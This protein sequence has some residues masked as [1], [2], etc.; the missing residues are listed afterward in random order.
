MGERHT[1]HVMG[2][3]LTVEIR[4]RVVPRR[5]LERAFGWLRWVDRTFSTYD[6]GS[7]IS[8][9]NAGDLGLSEAH[10]L[11]RRVLAR[12]ETLRAGT[13]GYFDANAPL[14]GGVDPS[15]LVKGWAVD[16]A[17]AGL[18]RA[19]AR[20]LCIEAG[21][22]LRVAG[23]P[24]RIGIRNPRRRDQLAAVVVLRNGAVATSGAYERGP[25]VVDPHTGRPPAGTLSVTMIDH[26]LA[27]ADAHATA[28]F[29][30][31]PRGPVWSARLTAMTILADDQVLLTPTFLRYRA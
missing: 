14:R 9:L 5:A 13:D 27:Q 6:A 24:W 25:H 4:D 21:G 12:C 29:A 7:E 16:V 31:G 3:A 23:G 19:G 10:P 11:V 15:G 20:Q 1:Q 2:T 26:T 17:F 22:D 18:R 28:A 30:M 8:R